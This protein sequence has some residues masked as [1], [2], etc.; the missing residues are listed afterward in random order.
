MA[1]PEAKV[2]LLGTCEALEMGVRNVLDPRVLSE[3]MLG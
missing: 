3:I 1:L 2:G